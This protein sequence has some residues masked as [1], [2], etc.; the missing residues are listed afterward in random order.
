MDSAKTG[1][2]AD[3]LT[4]PGTALINNQSGTVV[5]LIK[6]PVHDAIIED[7]QE[8]RL[9]EAVNILST[10]SS[11]TECMKPADLDDACWQGMGTMLR[12]AINLIGV[13]SVPVS[14]E[15]PLT[16]D[17]DVLSSVTS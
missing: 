2:K 13:Q 7:S 10:M 9:T 16:S 14:V 1:F 17:N 15:L 5:R 12:R 4:E 11:I 3:L 6:F 8:I